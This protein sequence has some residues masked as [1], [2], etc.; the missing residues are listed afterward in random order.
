VEIENSEEKEESKSSGRDFGLFEGRTM[1]GPRGGG[2]FT[3]DGTM[4]ALLRRG[5]GQSRE[6][7]KETNQ[8][9]PDPRGGTGY[10]KKPTQLKSGGKTV[11]RSQRGQNYGFS[12]WFS[13]QG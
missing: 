4:R 3:P 10:A 7:K 11:S 2:Q 13:K 12:R 9:N 1:R 8:R 6:K 5:V